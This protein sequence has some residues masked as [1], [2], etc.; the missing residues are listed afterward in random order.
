MGI[1]ET[2]W[3]EWEYEAANTRKMMG[4][5]PADKWDYK[6]H[7][8]SFTMGQLVSHL[9]EIPSW[10]PDTMAETEYVLDME[11]YVPLYFDTPEAALAAF[12]AEMAKAKDALLAASDKDFMVQ[13]SMKDPAGNVMFSLPRIGVVRSMFLNHS[14][15]HRAQLGLYLRLNDVPVPGIYGPSADEQM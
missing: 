6:P 2:I 9:A 3:Q 13:W 15:H 4:C 14:V 5:A 1:G 11:K 8:K 7:E 10:T 12:D